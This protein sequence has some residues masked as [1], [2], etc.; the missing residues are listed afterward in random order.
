MKISKI[1]YTTSPA[2]A[3]QNQENIRQVMTDLQRLAH[4]GINY[5]A[6]LCADGKTFIHTVFFRTDEDQKLLG[7]LPSFQYF[8]AQLKASAPEMPP[9]QE[10]LMLVGTANDIFGA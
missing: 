6:C 3:S 2:Y 9:K 5:N 1:T 7:E 4:P 10:A 8:Q